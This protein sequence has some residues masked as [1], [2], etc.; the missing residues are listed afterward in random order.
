MRAMLTVVLLAAALTAG[1]YDA[2][3]P[4]TTRDAG[5]SVEASLR[6][7]GSGVSPRVRRERKVIELVNNK[8]ANHGCRPVKERLTLR[9]AA[10]RHSR[11]MAEHD[12]FSHGSSEYMIRRI[13]RAGYTGW[14]RLGENLAKSNRSG[15]G[16][17]PRQVVR[18]WMHSPGHRK[19]IL[20]CKFRHLGVGLVQDSGLR[21]WTQDF[22]R[23]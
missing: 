5:P 9:K 22:G 17:T 2:R 1:A 23:K 21:W 20:N 16:W 18:S 14:T 6:L 7:T 11:R 13:E 19:N 12:W 15:A 4:A 8:R 10:R 3:S